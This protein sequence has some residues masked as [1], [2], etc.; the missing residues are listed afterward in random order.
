MIKHI[1]NLIK[2]RKD[3]SLKREL[4]HVKENVVRSFSNIKK[5]MEDQ[6]K[7]IDHLHS[8]HKQI[9]SLYSLLHDKHNH[10]QKI[11]VRDIDNINRWIAH[12]NE[13][14][15]KQEGALKELETNISLAFDKYNKYL[16]D[17]YRVVVD[18]KSK[19]PIQNLD[20]HGRAHSRLQTRLDAQDELGRG[21]SYDGVITKTGSELNSIP[22]AVSDRKGAALKETKDVKAPLEHYSNVLTR[23]EK[24]I[25]AELCNTSH[26]LSYKDLAVMTGVSS[27]TVK[28]HICHIKNKG[29]PI[30]ETNDRSGVK[31]Y[32]VQDNIKKVLLSKTM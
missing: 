11:H 26:K 16:I 9:D 30:K 15:K 13:T 24:N 3:D 19:T 6:K 1:R 5:D 12:L 20:A 27:N 14:S 29:F 25:L 17:I 21:E 18:M 23:S 7:W 8:N 4:S 28:N 31:R 2:S 10:H 22:V 32:F